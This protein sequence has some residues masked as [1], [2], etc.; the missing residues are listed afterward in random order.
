MPN[1]DA[2]LQTLQQ[3]GTLNPRPEDVRDE[4][5]LQNGFFDPRDL[6]QVKYEMLCRVETDGKSVTEAATRFGFSRPS[7]Y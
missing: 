3:Q 2:K 1:P 6:V 5:F 4:L 7:F